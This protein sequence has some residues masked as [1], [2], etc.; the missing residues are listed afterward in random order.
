ME[1]KAK[2]FWADMPSENNP[3]STPR[4]GRTV[5]SVAY[6]RRM[7]RSIVKEDQI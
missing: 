3:Q 4:G 1:I 7:I 6:I 5:R 2:E